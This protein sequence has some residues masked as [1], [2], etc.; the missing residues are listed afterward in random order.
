MLK[1]ENPP[2]V[3][4]ASGAVNCLTAN[5]DTKYSLNPNY[6]QP[7]LWKEYR[8]ALANQHTESALARY[9]VTDPEATLICGLTRI[10]PLIHTFEPADNGDHAI[11]LPVFDGYELWDLIT[12]DPRAP[13]IWWCRIGGE[14]MLGCNWLGNA[15]HTTTVRVFPNP[16]AWLQAGCAGVVILDKSKSFEDLSLYGLPGLWIMPEMVAA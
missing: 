1:M 8:P 12:F 3:G 4:A 9:G 14:P 15:D 2:A 6:Q 16:L 5:S 10:K 13:E 7:D 11:L